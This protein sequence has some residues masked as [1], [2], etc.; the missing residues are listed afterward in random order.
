MVTENTP[1]DTLNRHL[2]DLRISVTDRCNLRCTYCMP[3]E[4]FG[5]D[6]KFL[7]RSEILDYEELARLAR[8]FAQ[9]GVTKLR[10]TGGEPL[11]RRNLPDFIAMLTRIPGIDDIA[12]TT[13]GILLP[14]LAKPLAEAGLNRVTVSLDSLDDKTFGELNGRGTGV[15]PVLAGIAAAE[16]AG[17]GP[18]KVN[19]VVQRG[20]NDKDI[21]PMA[22][23]FRGSGRILRFIEFMDVGTTNGWRMDKVVPSREI[24]KLIHERWPLES[25]EPN[26]RGEVA[27]RWL[28][29]DGQG[30]VGFISS[31]TNTFC[32]DCTRARL[33]ARGELFTCLFAAE[34]MDLREPLREGKTD[35]ELIE[36]VSAR[37]KARDDRYS[38]IRNQNT[39]GIKKAEMSYLG[40]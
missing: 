37:W 35:A 36:L 12:L 39:A 3:A 30:E 31:V 16:K 20:V 14:T 7:P 15:K 34:G 6:Y 26:Y 28:Y 5:P 4:V 21:L 18:V 10:I 11:L 19:M 25:A 27:R 1:T 2:R 9:L 40:G 32:G 17:L 33:S 29:K 24:Q 13:N 8:V 23:H 22:E 38:E